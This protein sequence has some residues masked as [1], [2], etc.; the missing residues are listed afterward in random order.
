MLQKYRNLRPYIPPP[1]PRGP[2]FESIRYP[3][4]VGSQTDL[5]ECLEVLLRE[6]WANDRGLL[7]A[8]Q[9]LFVLA[10]VKRGFKDYWD[11]EPLED[12]SAIGHETGNAKGP[13]V[14]L[15]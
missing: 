9:Q 8:W 12:R 15:N 1:G 14:T 2:M 7:N 5:N 11:L 6:I 4:F 3:K 13:I 10:C